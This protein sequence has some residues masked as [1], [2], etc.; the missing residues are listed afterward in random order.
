[1]IRY[2]L[3]S[4]CLLFIYGCATSNNSVVIGSSH[5]V[6]YGMKEINDSYWWKCQFIINWP[7]GNEPDWAVDHLL[8]HAVVSPALSQYAENIPYWRF[9]RRAAR[10][11]SK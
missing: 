8:A 1:M 10:D 5:I 11:S 7:A 3:F 4:V 2:L 9:H 6:P